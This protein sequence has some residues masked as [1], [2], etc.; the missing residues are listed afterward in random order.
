MHACVC[1]SEPDEGLRSRA[2]CLWRCLQGQ[3]VGHRPSHQ[4]R[5]S[6]N[7]GG[8]RSGGSSPFQSPGMPT[9]QGTAAQP[10]LGFHQHVGKPF[11]HQATLSDTDLVDVAVAVQFAPA[12]QPF[13]MFLQAADSHR[14][15]TSLARQNCNALH[16]VLVLVVKST[17][18]RATSAMALSCCDLQ[19]HR[20]IS[21]S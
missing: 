9:Q 6:T 17:T 3:A 14:L 11:G 8:V 18:Q 16:A 13:L 2:K 4:G 10:H 1:C 20:V 12:Q 15:N 21:S 5:Y 7:S 19:G